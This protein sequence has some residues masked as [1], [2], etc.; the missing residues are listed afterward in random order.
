MVA[1]P[2]SR[3]QIEEYATLEIR[4]EMRRAYL[5]KGPCRL[6]GHVFPRKK[7]GADWRGFKEA[8]YK[9]YDWLEYSV[10]KDAAYCFYCFL[11]KPPSIC[12]EQFGHDAFKKK[13]FTNWKKAVEYFRTHE[14]KPNSAHNNARKNCED[15]RNQKQS[16]SYALTCHT[17][18]SHVQYEE[19]LRAVV[20]VARFLVSQGLAFR[21]TTSL[22]VL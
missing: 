9:S 6:I 21:G 8:W 17:E 18:K 20:G 10:E 12:S 4:D 3:R 15:F 22:R 5:S 11:F 16:V 1:D 2:G 13:G 14:G 19:R 7:I